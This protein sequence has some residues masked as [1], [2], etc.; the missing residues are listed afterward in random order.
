[1]KSEQRDLL[2][3][4]TSV[5][6]RLFKGSSHFEGEGGEVAQEPGEPGDEKG[7]LMEREQLHGTP[8]WVL[9]NKVDGYFLAFGK[10]RIG[11]VFNDKQGVLDFLNEEMWTVVGYLAGII[12]EIVV[13]DKEKNGT[14]SGETVGNMKTEE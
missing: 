6:E 11:G 9:G 13:N 8:F 7:E 12:A 4:Q 1:M 3:S 5:E 2:K 10:Y 14:F